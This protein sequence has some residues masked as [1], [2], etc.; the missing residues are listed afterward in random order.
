MFDSSVLIASVHTQHQ[1]IMTHGTM[2]ACSST[3]LNSAIQPPAY[4]TRKSNS[5][6]II[7]R[8]GQIVVRICIRSRIQVA[9]A[10]M[11]FSKHPGTS[12]RPHV[13]VIL[14]RPFAMC[15]HVFNPECNK[16]TINE[17]LFPFRKTLLSR[18]KI[19]I[20]LLVDRPSHAIDKPDSA[21]RPF[22]LSAF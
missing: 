19:Y 13:Y 7:H 10:I 9:F 16:S 11:C 4:I 8:K 3:E 5:I 22:L 12:G 2:E 18:L 17:S 14:L 15:M 6:T 20:M 21:W 1:A